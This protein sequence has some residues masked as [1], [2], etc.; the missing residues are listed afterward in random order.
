MDAQRFFCFIFSFFFNETQFIE[1]SARTILPAQRL[2]LSTFVSSRPA[3]FRQWRRAT[4][5]AH[6]SSSK[7]SLAYSD[8]LALVPTKPNSLCTCYCGNKFYI[9]RF[10][11]RARKYYPSCPRECLPLS[12]CS[13]LQQPTTT[14]DNN[15]SAR[16]SLFIFITIRL[17]IFFGN[18]RKQFVFVSLSL[19]YLLWF[20]FRF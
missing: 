2:S 1:N 9:S 5:L 18:F 20:V 16:I 14:T 13:L 17:L 6:S 4:P 8:Q 3:S 12:P 11:I 10:L 7:R 15:A 19:I